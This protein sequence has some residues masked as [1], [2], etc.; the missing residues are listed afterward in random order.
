MAQEAPS[1]TKGPFGVPK[2]P[3]RVAEVRPRG[4]HMVAPQVASSGN[5]GRPFG[6]PRGTF[7]RPREALWVADGPPKGPLRTA[8]G[9]LWDLLLVRL[10]SLNPVSRLTLAHLEKPRSYNQSINTQ[11]RPPPAS[12]DPRLTPA[13]RGPGGDLR[14]PAVT[15]P[16]PRLQAS[17]ARAGDA[18]KRIN[19]T[20]PLHVK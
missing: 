11:C 8:K 5:P 13:G 3:L 15:P 14:R 16:R 2:G 6:R 12:S 17:R 10:S 9:T 20:I 7:R 18:R 19:I 4:S 1:A